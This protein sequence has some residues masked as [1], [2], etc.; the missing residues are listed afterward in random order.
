M[1]RCVKKEDEVNEQESARPV[2]KQEKAFTGIW[3]FVAM[4]AVVTGALLLWLQR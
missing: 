3:L 1:V 4:V 2:L